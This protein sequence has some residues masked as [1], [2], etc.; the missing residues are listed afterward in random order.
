MDTYGDMVT[1]LLC[2][3]VL[4]Y[5]FSSVDAEKWKEL[6]GAFSGRYGA[7]EVIAFDVPS[8]RE[9]PID[10]IDPIVN[11]E[12]RYEDASAGAGQSRIEGEFSQ[13]YQVI[14]QYIQENGLGDSLSV[15]RTE[16]AIYLRFNEMALFQPG[17]ADILPASREILEHVL[18]VIHLNSASISAVKI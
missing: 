3:F 9:D 4:L 16:E 13:L 14:L 11:Y 8:V 15:S 1:L 18:Q 10:K 17:R 5:S 2:F 6:V 7:G 12:N